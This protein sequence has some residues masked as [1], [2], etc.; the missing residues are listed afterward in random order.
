MILRLTLLT[1]LLLMMTVHPGLSKEPATKLKLDVSIS[2]DSMVTITLTNP[3]DHPQKYYDS[4]THYL[5]EVPAFSWVKFRE[6][7]GTVILNDFFEDGRW[8]P[9]VYSSSEDGLKEDRMET[10][11]PGESTAV[12]FPI[13]KFLNR[14]PS[15]YFK[16]FYSVKFICRVFEV[17][18]GDNYVGAETD[19][20]VVDFSKV[21]RQRNNF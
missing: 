8:T 2:E 13:G 12:S 6:K 10:L 4:L 3:S 11:Y 18:S 5:T 7:S 20:V 16:G 21:L 17:P 19:W 14:A 9:L 1:T 15:Q